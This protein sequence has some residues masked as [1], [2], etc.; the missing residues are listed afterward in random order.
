VHIR[1]QVVFGGSKVI[2]EGSSEGE[3]QSISIPVSLSG[4]AVTYPVTITLEVNEE[5]SDVSGNDYA[6][7]SNEVVIESS[8]TADLNISILNDG[9]SESDE[10]LVLQVVSVSSGAVI[11][12]TTS[13][14]RVLIV[15]RNVAPDV[16]LTLQQGGQQSST[17]YQDAGLASLNVLAS[18]ANQDVLSVTWQLDSISAALTASTS[19][20]DETI[21]FDPALLTVGELYQVMVTVSD[22]ESTTQGFQSFVVAAQLPNLQAGTDSDGDGIDDQTEGLGDSDGDGVPDYQDAVNDPTRLSAGTDGGETTDLMATESGLQMSMGST[23]LSNGQGGA[24]IR[25]DDITDGS[26]VVVEDGDYAV[27]GGLYDFVVKGLTEAN[28]VAKVVI[29]LAQSVPAG[30]SYRKFSNGEWYE[31]IENGTDF[32]ESANKVD[33]VCPSPGSE[34]YQLGLLRFADCVQLNISDGG[35]ND[36][37]SEINGVIVDPSGVGAI[38]SAVSNPE[39]VAPTSQ[40]SGSGG[41]VDKFVLVM[42]F[43]LLWLKLIQRWFS[44]RRFYQQ[45][46]HLKRIRSGNE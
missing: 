8:L 46:M 11:S 36:A 14:Y 10:V 15:D 31:F 6:F 40:P 26:G 44:Q 29:P 37:D 1:P 4:D 2:G 35:P 45:T 30:A 19:N 38:P 13:E 25:S 3:T 16:S 17:L 24:L 43:G 27:V 22:G 32:V 28:R 42:L 20:V 21:I 5:A 33:G 39:L 12:D 41:A 7:N 18:D 34:L 23:A 9:I